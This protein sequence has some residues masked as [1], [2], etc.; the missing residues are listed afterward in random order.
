[1]SANAI[2]KAA[3]SPIAPVE[4]DTYEGKKDEYITF[5]YNSIPADFGDD[6]AGAE[7]L[8]VTVHLYAP[9]GRNV[10][11]KRRAIKAALVAAGATFPSYEN[12]SDKNGQ[13]HVFECEIVVG[14]G[15]E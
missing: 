4:A 8:L 3:L 10:L 11:A 1:M 9:A 15:A 12:L 14:A 2:L 7:R 5:G 13:N 6:E